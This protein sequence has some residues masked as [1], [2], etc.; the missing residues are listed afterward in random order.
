MEK[1]FDEFTDSYFSGQ[2]SYYGGNTYT[3]Y[4]RIEQ[5]AHDKFK[6]ALTFTP[7]RVISYFNDFYKSKIEES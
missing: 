5:E 1:L 6:K 4:Y 7:K 2:L 3:V